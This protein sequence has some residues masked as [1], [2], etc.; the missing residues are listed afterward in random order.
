MGRRDGQDRTVT[1]RKRCGGKYKLLVWRSLCSPQSWCS[2]GRWA[3]L[4]TRGGR[5]DLFIFTRLSH[6]DQLEGF[7]L[8]GM[9]WIQLW[10]IRQVLH[11]S[12]RDVDSCFPTLLSH[13]YKSNTAA[14]EP[15]QSCICVSLGYHSRVLDPA[16][17]NSH[18]GTDSWKRVWKILCRREKNTKYLSTWQI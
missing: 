1:E 10:V 18:R 8:W 17:K 7:Q 14:E 12:R 15:Q 2:T 6:C 5:G 11:W 16:N 3:A 13:H 9:I 4:S